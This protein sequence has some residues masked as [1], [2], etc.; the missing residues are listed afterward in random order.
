MTQQ[1]QGDYYPP[2]QQDP[3]QYQQYPPQQPS[4]QQYQ[5]P[6]PQ[7]EFYQSQ[8]RAAA[9]GQGIQAVDSLS[10]NEF[11]VEVNGQRVSGVF[12]VSGLSSYHLKMQ[13]GKPVGMDF[14]AIT[15]TKMVQQDP[16]LPFNQWTRETVAAR[17]TR[18]PTRD[19]SIVALD[20]GVETR[21]W[22]YRNCWISAIHFSD[23]DTALDFLIEE[24]VTIQHGGVEE[25]WPAR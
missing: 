7:G 5:Q 14:P 20:E 16:N 9:S 23:F 21:R 15:I 1:Y 24:K 13:D 3:Q 2:Q 6:A 10:A 8:A 18:L 4:Q 25:V 11:V 22:V 19:I 17:G 12:A